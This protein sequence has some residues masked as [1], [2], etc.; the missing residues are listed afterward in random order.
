MRQN[1]TKTL[2]VYSMTDLNEYK[3]NFPSNP[4]DGTVFKDHD[5]M[6]WL[7]S[8]EINNWALNLKNEETYKRYTCL[9]SLPRGNENGSVAISGA[10]NVFRWLDE[11]E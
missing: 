9:D 10:E 11:N 7:Y 8:E 1:C 6:E 5:N 2:R 4:T 3:I